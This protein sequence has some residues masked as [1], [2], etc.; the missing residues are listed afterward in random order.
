MC[1]EQGV[2]NQPVGYS[3][4]ATVITISCCTLKYAPKNAIAVSE[5]ATRNRLTNVTI[6][7]LRAFIMKDGKPR[8]NIQAIILFCI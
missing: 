4:L 3:L 1:I 2:W 6:N 7:E 8:A 5:Y